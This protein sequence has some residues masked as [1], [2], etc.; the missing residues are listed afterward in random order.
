MAGSP[1]PIQ[2][3]RTRL[4]QSRWQLHDGLQQL[5]TRLKE[6][7]LSPGAA[8]VSAD[9]AKWLLFGAAAGMVA[10][11]LTRRLWQRGR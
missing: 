7:P 4:E 2:E 11:E 10:L 1:S 5:D 8:P 6:A 9:L 3:L